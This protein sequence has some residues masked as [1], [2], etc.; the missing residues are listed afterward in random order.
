MKKFIELVK[1]M[2]SERYS[3]TMNKII[4]EKIPLTFLTIAPLESALETVKSL[5]GQGLLID[6]LVTAQN[7]PRPIICR[8]I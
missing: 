5:R 8:Q 4:S 3:V 6:N 7:P 2:H 1:R